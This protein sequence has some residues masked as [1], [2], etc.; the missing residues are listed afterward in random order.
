MKAAKL[1][2]PVAALE[3]AKIELRKAKTLQDRLVA[4]KDLETAAANNIHEAKFL[5]AHLIWQPGHEFSNQAR[6]IELFTSAANNGHLE[7]QIFLGDHYG[8]S[9]TAHFDANKSYEYFKLARLQSDTYA[10]YRIANFLLLGIGVQTDQSLGLRYLE[11]S[12]NSGLAEAQYLLASLI[13]NKKI[14]G[15][16]EEALSLFEAAA[17][18]GFKGAYAPL[19]TMYRMGIGTQI[20]LERLI[21]WYEMAAASGDPETQ[22]E[23]GMMYWTGNEI[24]PDKA[25]ARA[26]LQASADNG[27]SVGAYQFDFIILYCICES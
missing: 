9:E 1:G 8:D 27:L 7:S 3:N 6:A 16:D 4:I 12:A 23:L 5:L 19:G 21:H 26:L 25:K 24:L 11:Q 18:Q 13:L 14:S 10:Q 20:D 17:T 22:F 2:Q 15:T